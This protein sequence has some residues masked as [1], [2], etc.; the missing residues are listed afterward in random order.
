MRSWLI[1]AVLAAAAGCSPEEDDGG[2]GDRVE[3]T[4]A[5]CRDGIDNDGDGGADCDDFACLSYA[6]CVGGGDAG[7]GVDAGPGLD[8]GPRPDSGPPPTCTSPMDIAFVLDVSTS[9]A[10]DVEAIRN[11]LESI[12][13]ATHALTDNPRFGMI[14]FVDDALA[15]NDCAAFATLEEMQ[16]EFEVWR[17]FCSSNRSPV[18]SSTNSDCPENSLDAL[19]LAATQCSWRAD[20]THIVIHVTDDT[21][22]E[23]PDRFGIFGEG[24]AVQ[25]GYEE[26]VEALRAN[27]VRVGAFASPSPGLECGAGSS[28][29][30][31]AG[32]HDPY[33]GMPSIVERT[34]GRVWNI[35]ERRDMAEAINEFAEDEHCTLF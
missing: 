32:F 13:N 12:W 7:P 15:V 10:D 8:S 35:R 23:P 21:F 5:Q 20:S 25:H 3:V 28:P 19:Y 22:L 11:G 26:T 33:M 34:G 6:F 17:S 16:T 4:G 30:A 18:S 14:V 1:F 24:P 31:G 29:E 9:M 27:M 2:G